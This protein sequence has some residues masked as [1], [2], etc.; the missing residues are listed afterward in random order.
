MTLWCRTGDE[1]VRQ[2]LAALLRRALAVW[3]WQG[4]G[5][6]VTLPCSGRAAA[7]WKAECLCSG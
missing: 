3:L 7:V 2:L 5:F 4:L 1:V 6:D